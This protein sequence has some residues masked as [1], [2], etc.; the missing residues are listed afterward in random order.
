MQEKSEP[1]QMTESETRV[2]LSCGGNVGNAA[3]TISDALAEFGRRGLKGLQVSSFHRTRPVGCAP[4]AEPFTNGAAVGYWPDDAPS[5][6]NICKELET[7][8]GRPA[9]H[10]RYS[11][12]PLDLDIVLFGDSILRIPGLTVPHPECLTRLF[13]LVPL[14]EIAPDWIHPETGRSIGDHLSDWRNRDEYDDY[15]RFNEAMRSD[16]GRRQ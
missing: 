10:A 9:S 5:L 6:L 11:D 8:A 1:L 14:A 4:G 13:V 12:R 7:H 3:R 16:T 2:A 15:L